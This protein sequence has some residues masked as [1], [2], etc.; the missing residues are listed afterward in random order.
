MCS[1][2]PPTRPC[3][4]DSGV[5]VP[6][7]LDIFGLFQTSKPGGTGLGLPIARRIIEAHGGAITYTSVPGRGTEFVVSLKAD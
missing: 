7:D 3:E 6:P 2:A 5:G 4:C 1:T